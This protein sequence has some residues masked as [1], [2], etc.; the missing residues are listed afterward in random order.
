M[1]VSVYWS[2]NVLFVIVCLCMCDI[3][4]E[5]QKTHVSAFVSDQVRGNTEDIPARA[6]ET[7]GLLY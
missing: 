2:L 6:A 5:L 3:K 7:S 4:S 1:G